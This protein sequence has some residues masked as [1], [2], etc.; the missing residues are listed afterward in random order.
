M[1]I[2][3]KGTPQEKHFPYDEQGIAAA[4]QYAAENSL[5]IEMEDEKSP[6]AGAGLG[7]NGGPKVSEDRKLAAVRQMIGGM[8]Q[9]PGRY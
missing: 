5:P 2:V 3:G 9:G 8:G 7:G 1:P 6:T 4:K